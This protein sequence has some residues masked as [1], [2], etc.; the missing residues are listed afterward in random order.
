MITSCVAPIVVELAPAQVMGLNEGQPVLLQTGEMSN[1]E[2]SVTL[3]DETGQPFEVV[4]VP[5]LGAGAPAQSL[6]NTI[7]NTNFPALGPVVKHFQVISP[8]TR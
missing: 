6:Y 2:I 4:I 1:E 3:M 5:E 8:P 7:R